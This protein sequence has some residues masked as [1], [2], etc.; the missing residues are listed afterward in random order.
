MGLLLGVKGQMHTATG[1]FLSA[2]FYLFFFFMLVSLSQ[3]NKDVFF[4]LLFNILYVFFK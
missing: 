3:N 1:E 4:L 2:I